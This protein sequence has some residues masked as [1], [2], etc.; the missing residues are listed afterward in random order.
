MSEKKNTHEVRILRN[1]DKH[2]IEE[3]LDDGWTLNSI[4]VL[5]YSN[6]HGV[7]DQGTI[8]KEFY[9]IKVKYS[10]NSDI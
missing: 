8:V 5:P 4:I 6:Y 9:F 1:L 3:M 7:I 10:F 2:K